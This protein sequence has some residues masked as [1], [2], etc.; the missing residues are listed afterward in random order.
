MMSGEI[1]TTEEMFSSDGTLVVTEELVTKFET[2]NLEEA[3]PQG[4]GEWIIGYKSYR[5]GTLIESGRFSG[6]PHNIVRQQVRERHQLLS[7]YDG[8]DYVQQP[9]VKHHIESS[10]Q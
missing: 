9:T 6:W 8:Y 3:I 1:K 10:N 4:A 2:L 7:K 5:K